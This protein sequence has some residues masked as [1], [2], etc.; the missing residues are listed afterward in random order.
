MHGYALEIN[1]F[2]GVKPSPSMLSLKD[3]CDH[4][5]GP[6][7]LDPNWTIKIFWFGALSVKFRVYPL[8]HL[9][10]SQVVDRTQI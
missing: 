4:L 8:Y 2:L 5:S 10:C 3:M 1:R 6:L 7:A 9:V